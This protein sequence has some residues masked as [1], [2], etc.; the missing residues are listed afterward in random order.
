MTE[1]VPFLSAVQLPYLLQALSHHTA[2]D[3]LTW[4]GKERAQSES[5]DHPHCCEPAHVIHEISLTETTR[6]KRRVVRDVSFSSGC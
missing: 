5:A 3:T 2:L 4:P 6:Q 1:L